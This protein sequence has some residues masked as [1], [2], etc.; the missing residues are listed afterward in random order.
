M[1]NIEELQS[2]LRGTKA[3]RVGGCTILVGVEMG[4][5]HLSISH[6][7]RYPTWD[8]IKWSRYQ[9]CPGNITM[10]MLLPPMEEYVNIHERCFHLWQVQDDRGK[11]K[12]R[13]LIP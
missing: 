7:E 1:F 10:A 11:K 13:I 6:E 8:E 4:L 3:F 5:W 2:P 9:F 12:S